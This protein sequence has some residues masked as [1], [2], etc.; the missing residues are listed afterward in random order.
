[1]T[2]S[3][4]RLEDDQLER[5]ADLVAQRVDISATRAR[6]PLVDA[7]ELARLLG[8][9]RAAVYEHARELGAIRIGAGKKGRL[10]F[11]PEV[12]IRNASTAQSP[13][14]AA[15]AQAPRARSR[16][17]KRQ[18]AQARHPF[19]EPKAVWDDDTGLWRNAEGYPTH[20][21]CWQ[22]NVPGTHK[23]LAEGPNH[24]QGA[25]HTEWEA[26]RREWRQAHRQHAKPKAGDTPMPSRKPS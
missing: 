6:G 17:P 4:I 18:I 23:L 15:P 1:M 25:T 8:M 22:S 2:S 12:S 24:Q 3:F 20:D 13:A 21:Q 14:P 5:L 10:R 9:S 7:K 19:L 16:A 26:A 11:D